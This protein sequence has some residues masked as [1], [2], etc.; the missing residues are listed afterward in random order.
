MQKLREREVCKV[1][2]DLLIMAQA[3]QD[4]ICTELSPFPLHPHCCFAL[5]GTVVS[6]IFSAQAIFFIWLGL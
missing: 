1:L 3:A 5:S 2:P 4:S 6:Y